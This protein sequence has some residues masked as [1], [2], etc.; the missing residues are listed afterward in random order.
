MPELDVLLDLAKTTA[1]RAAERL[2]GQTSS[3]ERRY[4][5]SIAYPREIKA[6][7][8]SVMEQEIV[9]ALAVSE[10]P[11]LSEESGI[12]AS[13]HPSRFRFIVDPLDGTFNYVKGLGPSAISIALWEDERPVFGVIYSLPEQ[14]LTWGGLDVG[15]FVEGR[16]ISVSDTSERALASICTGFPVRLDMDLERSMQRFWRTVKPYAK[17]RMLGSAAASLLHVA[18]GSAD[19]YSESRIMLWDIAAGIAIVQGAGGDYVM[20]HAGGEE[21]CYEVF[22]S[23]PALLACCADEE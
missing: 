23:N 20:K 2:L 3:A 11:I 18:D 8:D 13:Q 4:V 19:V 16:R 12:I 10:L 21:W 22:A 5:H 1:T 14:R 9:R 17:V 7:I 15:A 6:I